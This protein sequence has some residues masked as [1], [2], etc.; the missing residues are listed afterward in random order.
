MSW[1]GDGAIVYGENNFVRVHARWEEGQEWVNADVD[2]GLPQ[3]EDTDSTKAHR[4]LFDDNE[5]TYAIFLNNCLLADDCYLTFRV[6]PC[7]RGATAGQTR[8]LLFLRLKADISPLR[9]GYATYHPG[10]FHVEYTKSDGTVVT[11]LSDVKTFDGWLSIY[12]D[13]KEVR[14]IGTAELLPQYSSQHKVI[15]MGFFVMRP[16]F[17]R[18]SNVYCRTDKTIRF[19]IPETLDRVPPGPTYMERNGVSVNELMLVRYDHPYATPIRVMTVTGLM[20]LVA[21]SVST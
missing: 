5:N 20:A 16:Y 12:D 11:A 8:H 6:I 19:A 4:N 2:D 9:I 3:Y 14:L 17:A 10:N 13:V 21:Y 7:N 18:P 1:I 15:K